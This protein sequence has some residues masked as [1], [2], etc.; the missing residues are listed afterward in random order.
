MVAPIDD[1]SSAL[2]KGSIYDRREDTIRSNP[3]TTRRYFDL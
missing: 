1:G 2:K 3:M